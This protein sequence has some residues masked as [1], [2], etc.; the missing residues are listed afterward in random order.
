MRMTTPSRDS[1]VRVRVRVSGLVQGVGF[2][3]FVWREASIRQLCGWVG[4][5]A[6]GVVMEVEGPSSAVSDLLTALRV[7]PPLARVDDIF[8]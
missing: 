6:A 2:R 5:D 8:S 3:P 1:A 7:P 4:N